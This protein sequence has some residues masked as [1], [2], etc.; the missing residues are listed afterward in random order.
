MKETI[1]QIETCEFQR[2]SESD[3]EIGLLLNEG[4]LGIIDKFGKQTG[5]VWNWRRISAFV[6]STDLAKLEKEYQV[7]R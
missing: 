7:S 3:W 1:W 2:S 6:L 4:T 5:M